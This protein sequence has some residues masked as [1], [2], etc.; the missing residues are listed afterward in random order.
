MLMGKGGL[1]ATFFEAMENQDS[2]LWGM[3]LMMTDLI[4]N[5]EYRK[6]AAE[7]ID[8]LTKT[9]I[10]VL[11]AANGLPGNTDM[12]EVERQSRA[13][14]ENAITGGTHTA[15]LVFDRD[16]FVGTGGIS[17][18]QVMPTWHNPT[19]RKGY[20]MNMYTRSEYRRKGI[21]YHMLDLLIQDAREKGV[22]FI[23]LEATAAGRPLYEK[24]GFSAMAGEMELLL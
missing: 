3:F 13:Y 24:Y 15:F 6:A 2:L 10:E 4:Q 19:G 9:R 18:Y 1:R 16:R 8:L 14:Y 20:I 5:P 23:S 17:Y 22:S 21:A 12:S 11:L 7:D